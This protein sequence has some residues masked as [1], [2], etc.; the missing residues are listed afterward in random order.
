VAI[1]SSSGLP[2]FL[3]SI[4]NSLS[5][6]VM[7]NMLSGEV[8]AFRVSIGLRPLPDFSFDCAPYIN[9]Y[10]VMPLLFFFNFTS[11]SFFES[12]GSPST[13]FALG[14]RFCF[15]SVRLNVKKKQK[16][17]TNLVNSSWPLARL[18]NL[19]L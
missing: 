17:I 15:F 14:T 5:I 3:N 1:S 13:D 6:K 18:L 11:L 16:N 4:L 8:N 12:Y 10:S 2:Q 7:W 19:L 9:M